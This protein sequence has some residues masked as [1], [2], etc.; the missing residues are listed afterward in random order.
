MLN[1]NAY[2]W[3]KN[4]GHLALFVQVDDL[5]WGKSVKPGCRS[6]AIGPYI[7]GIDQILDFELRQLFGQGD[8]I[9]SIAS[10]PKNGADLRFAPLERFQMILA[11]VENDATEGVINTIIDIVAG[12]AIPYSLPDD[13][14]NRGGGGGYQESAGFRQDL[15]VRGEE[16]VN[17]AINFLR[18]RAERFHVTV[19]GRREASSYIENFDFPSA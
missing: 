15:D 10:L 9:Q 4:L 2:S 6:A 3:A 19:I 13:S 5:S 7:L 16:P 12:F 8:G 1:C 18:Q 17:L 11:M 14:C